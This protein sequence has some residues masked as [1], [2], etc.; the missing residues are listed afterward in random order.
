MFGFKGNEQ[1]AISVALFLVQRTN[2]PQRLPKKERYFAVLFLCLNSN[3][4][5][6]KST[7]AID[8]CLLEW[9]NKFNYYTKG[10]FYGSKL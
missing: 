5:F 7:I 9:Y 3:F 6:E 2:F 10:Y 1:F 8:F 4:L